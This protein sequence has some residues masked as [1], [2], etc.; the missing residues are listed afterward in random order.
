[1]DLWKGEYPWII[2][3]MVMKRGVSN[4]VEITI[5]LHWDPVQAIACLGQQA[6]MIM[7]GIGLTV[8]MV[9]GTTKR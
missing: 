3:A 2:K 6:M 7:Y 8:V 9:I 5:V 1:M 4:L